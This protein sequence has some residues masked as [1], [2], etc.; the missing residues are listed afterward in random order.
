MLRLR[1]LFAALSLIFQLRHA[2]RDAL[3][4]KYQGRRLPWNKL[5]A[6]ASLYSKKT[7]KRVAYFFLSSSARKHFR[8]SGIANIALYKTAVSYFGGILL[9]N[10]FVKSA[11]LKNRINFVRQ[12]IKCF[13]NR[14]VS[15]NVVQFIR[16]IQNT[17]VCSRIFIKKKKINYP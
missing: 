10:F 8:K 1:L 14:N 5:R 11:K 16:Q 15:T 17:D 6:V 3:T 12:D 13:L 4:I 7:R 2:H 9:C